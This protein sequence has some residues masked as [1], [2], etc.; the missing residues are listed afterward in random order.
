PAII[1]AGSSIVD[2]YIGPYT[3]ID[4]G[5]EVTGS[6][7]E[8]SIVLAG[9]SIVDLEMRMEGSLLGRDVRLAR[10]HGMPKTLR[11]L[12]GDHADIEI[13]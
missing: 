6:E 7:I 8:H 9:S 10:S 1:G 2:S 3:A 4:A 12:V 13:P 5:V 11:L